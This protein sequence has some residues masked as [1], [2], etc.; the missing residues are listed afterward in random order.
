[1]A[2]FDVGITRR[3]SNRGSASMLINDYRVRRRPKAG[4][5]SR[6][7]SY[8]L[9]GASGSEDSASR[10]ATNYR[11]PTGTRNAW[12]RPGHVRRTKRTAYD[13]WV[14]RGNV[15]YI[16]AYASM[17]NRRRSFRRQ[18]RTKNDRSQGLLWWVQ[19]GC[20][21]GSTYRRY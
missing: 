5:D 3:V 21:N 13:S 20:R 7:T 9:R 6:R 15:V 18:V 11:H 12:S 19:L 16:R 10:R 8:F 4:H 2:F 17:R 14:Y 1:M